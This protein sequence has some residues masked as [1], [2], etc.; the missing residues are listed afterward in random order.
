MSK[1]N[2]KKM[3]VFFFMM[4]G[5]AA[6]IFGNPYHLN[7]V[8]AAENSDIGASLDKIFQKINQS[9]FSEDTL[10]S[11][12]KVEAQ[13][14]KKGADNSL[15]DVNWCYYAYVYNLMFLNRQKE[16]GPMMNRWNKLLESVYQSE[17]DVNF[18]YAL[19]LD[20]DS[21]RFF[22]TGILLGP[23]CDPLLLTHTQNL[24]D[25]MEKSCEM[26]PDLAKS[27]LQSA[28]ESLAYGLLYNRKFEE[29]GQTVSKMLAVEDQL[30]GVL[31][32]DY[33]PVA[34]YKYLLEGDYQKGEKILLNVIEILGSS[35]INQLLPQTVTTVV[36]NDLYQMKKRGIESK[37][38]DKLLKV[39]PEPIL[40]ITGV[41]ANSPADKNGLL[42]GD[43]INKYQ[44]VRCLSFYHFMDLVA[45]HLG[46]AKVELEIIRDNKT[47]VVTVP[48]GRLGI[49]IG[50]DVKK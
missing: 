21:D 3:M 41:R 8:N 42:K 1:K 36:I 16:A 44:G 20:L 27:C 5:F 47:M 40:N 9:D 37:N 49:S 33:M 19:E 34:A 48:S 32:E 23:E 11:I 10:A 39:L 6:L 35:K 17:P 26:D 25:F 18:D 2:K 14:Y 43:Q 29:F 13:V 45:A 38:V 7:P 12:R 22:Y 15:S 4:L 50:E 31:P 46:E 24:A 30:I 28:L